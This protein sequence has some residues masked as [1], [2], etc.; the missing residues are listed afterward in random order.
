MCVYY[1]ICNSLPVDKL[2]HVKVK[3]NLPLLLIDGLM[4]ACTILCSLC[5]T[6]AGEAGGSGAGGSG[7]GAATGPGAGAASGSGGS[8]AGAAGSLAAGEAGGLLAVAVLASAAGSR[9]AVS[10]GSQST[11]IGTLCCCSANI[12]CGKRQND[13]H[14]EGTLR[15][16]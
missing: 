13:E 10:W 9:A 3:F 5:T 4:L 7:A 2:L 8:G 11:S 15:N 1:N 6:G 14:T 12:S 16:Y